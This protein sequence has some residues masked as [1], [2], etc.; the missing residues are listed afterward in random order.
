MTRRRLAALA[1]LSGAVFAIGVALAGDASA[2]ASVVSSDPANGA[3]LKSAPGTV[4]ITF[5]EPVGLG[6][7]GYLHVVD[8]SGKRVETGSAFH[9]GGAGRTIA[10]RLTSGLGDGTYTESFRVVSADSHPVAGTVRFVVG[11]GVLSA[12][13]AAG[14]TVDRPLSVTFDVLRWVSFGGFAALGGTWLLLTVWAPGRGEARARRLVWTGWAAAVVGGV[15][16]LVLQGPY[17]AGSGF[18]DVA[19]WTLLDST[20]HTD[21]GMYRCVRLVLL[22]AVALKLGWL[23]DRPRARFDPLALVLLPAIALTFSATGHAATTSP[24]WLSISADLLHLTAMSTWI[25]GLA[26]LLLAVLP[27]GEPDE[28]AAVL[29][30][31][32]RVALA[33]V[34]VL[35]VT[36]TYSAWHGVGTWGALF[37]TTYGELVVVKVGLFVCIVA[38]ADF[39]RR[40]VQRRWANGTERIR[41]AVAVELVLALAVFA[42]TAVLVSEPRGREALAVSHEHPRAAS[43]PLGNGRSVTVTVDP[44]THGTVT[45]SVEL[46]DGPK[47]QRITGTAYLPSKQLGPI[48]IGL[49]ANGTNIYGASGIELPSAGSWDFRLVVT[50]SEFDATTVDVI[51]RLY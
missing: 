41:R 24:G 34:V 10:A 8:T 20:L 51:V 40:T 21:Y 9:P 1:L 12:A 2:H 39:G 17:T 35:A 37:S 48:P 27:R 45:V 3:R 32:S 23:L 5:D 44:G 14:A 43:S 26:M 33:S 7:V 22:G 47:V 28:L 6:T 11:N 38:V 46:E 4:T 13:P 42:A 18:G 50:T 29:P 16:E 49:T 31:V 19:K 25:G 36:G 15:A 30:V